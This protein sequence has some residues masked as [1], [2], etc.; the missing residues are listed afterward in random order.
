VQKANCLSTPVP[1][2]TRSYLKNRL[3]VPGKKLELCSAVCNL[4]PY[5]I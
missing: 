3:C 4:E 1:V 5:V 2:V